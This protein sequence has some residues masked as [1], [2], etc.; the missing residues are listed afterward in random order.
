[1]DKVV[2]FKEIEIRMH[3]LAKANCHKYR[4]F[5]NAKNT[6]AELIMSLEKP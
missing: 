5:P 4:A 1:L 6:V 2:K 3:V